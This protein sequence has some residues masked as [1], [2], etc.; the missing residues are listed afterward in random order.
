LGVIAN[1]LANARGTDRTHDRKGVVV[2][3]PA[4]QVWNYQSDKFF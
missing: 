3:D 4:F 2:G 1:P